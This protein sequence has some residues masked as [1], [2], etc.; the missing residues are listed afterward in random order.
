MVRNYR[1]RRRKY[2]MPGRMIRVRFGIEQEANRQRAE[3]FN[4]VEDR[5]RIRRI[6]PAVDQHD[7]FL[8]QDDAAI[9]IE[10]SPDV[11]VD[12]V[13][14]LLEIRRQLLRVNG[15]RIH[16]QREKRRQRVYFSAS[17]APP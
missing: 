3:L 14:E 12:A 7:A 6:V 4:R 8:S 2:K 1:R 16:Q 13:F 5:A 10:I 17:Y 9:G 11:D 15:T